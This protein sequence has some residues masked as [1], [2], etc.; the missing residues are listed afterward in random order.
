[1]KILLAQT[2]NIRFQ[3]ELDVCITNIR[4]LDKKIPIVLL[5]LR[6]EPTGMETIKHFQ[7]R[8]ENTEIHA[9]LDKR[10]NKSYPAT[11]RP[12]LIHTYL[13]EDPKRENENYFQI[14]SDVIFRE[15]PAFSKMSLNGKICWGSDC[16]S[17]I[18]YN[19]LIGCEKGEKIVEGFSKI[20]NFQEN[21]IKH[22]P[23]I[24]AQFLMSN[25]T[26][27]LWWHIWRDSQLIYDYLTPI[28]SNIQKWTAEMWAQLYNL[29]KFGWEVKI[30]PEL[31]FC[32]PT[33]LIEKWDEVKILHNAGVVGPKTRNLFFKGK[34]DRETPFGQNFDSVDKKKASL[35]YVQ[36]IERVIQ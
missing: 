14:D 21:Q 31:D 16:S 32:R 4:S 26:A 28:N 15:L 5:F 6:G 2:A 8:Y 35:R 7:G 33:D 12:Y 22:I 23:G 25:P 29:H 24:G 13:K 18:D 27:I 9:Y 1:M 19:Y 30:A 20:L 3:W 34:Y 10:D 11:T 17:Y 36:A